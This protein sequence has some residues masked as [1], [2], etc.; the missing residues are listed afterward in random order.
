LA[1]A[2]GWVAIATTWNV[3]K[4]ELLAERGADH[5]V[6]DDKSIS[7]AVREIRPGGP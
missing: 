3:A 1:K 2:R 5:V 4:V 7:R 6:I